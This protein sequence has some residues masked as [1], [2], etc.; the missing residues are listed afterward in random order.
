ML[1]GVTPG[2]ITILKKGK[3]TNA[4]QL[5]CSEREQI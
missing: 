1:Y 5:E 4:L 3:L 2:E